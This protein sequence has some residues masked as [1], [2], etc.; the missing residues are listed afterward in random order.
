MILTNFLGLHISLFHD[1]LIHWAVNNSPFFL[2]TATGLFNLVKNS[3]FENKTV[4]KIS[5]LS[6][7]I[8]V[9]HDNLLLRAYIRPQ[10]WIYIHDT[11]GY[12]HLI[13]WVFALAA[14][15]FVFALVSAV[16]YRLVLQK[17]VY[18]FAD[19]VYEKF[20]AFFGKLTDK[21]AELK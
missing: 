6:L 11:W 1:K 9:I 17:L 16:I 12:S 21:I 13:L 8:Y 2:M 15:I 3:T 4:N 18:G 10:M 14:V 5:S 19:R 7:L 20:G